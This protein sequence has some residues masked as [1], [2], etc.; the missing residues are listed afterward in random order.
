[1]K[2][3][4]ICITLLFMLTACIS[5][6]QREDIEG[7]YRIGDVILFQDFEVIVGD[8]FINVIELP[9]NPNEHVLYIYLTYPEDKTIFSK[10]VWLHTMTKI[11]YNYY[12]VDGLDYLGGTARAEEPF[13]RFSIPNDIYEVVFYLSAD[14]RVYISIG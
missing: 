2:Y 7:T 4:M 9:Q 1:M 13:V 5:K 3:M 14:I 11:R 10:D 12:S 6:P 8:A